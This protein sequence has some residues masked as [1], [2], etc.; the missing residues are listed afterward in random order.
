MFLGFLAEKSQTLFEY[1]SNINIHFA[2]KMCSELLIKGR[3]IIHKDLHYMKQLEGPK[4]S[5]NEL[6]LKLDIPDALDEENGLKSA[7]I[8]SKNTFQFPAC[9]IR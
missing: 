7:Q 4:D 5:S 1:A 9:Y 8:I 3:K 2:N 6:K